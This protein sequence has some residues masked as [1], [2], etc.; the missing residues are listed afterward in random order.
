MSTSLVKE[1]VSIGLIS[2]IRPFVYRLLTSV[3]LIPTGRKVVNG[4]A[5]WVNRRSIAVDING[6]K[7]R[8]LAGLGASE[9]RASTLHRKEPETLDWIAHL[10][11]IV[12]FGT[13]VP[14]LAFI[15]FT[16]LCENV[17]K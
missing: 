17:A 16:Q 5:R 13:S 15:P 1:V 14:A 2:R 8:F 10:N 11:P 7:L 3:Y 6:T 12:L 9:W 4:I